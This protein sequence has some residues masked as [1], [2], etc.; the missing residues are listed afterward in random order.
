MHAQSCLTLCNPMDCR[1]PGSSSFAHGILQARIL[2]W[3]A[4]SSSRGPSQP[5]DQTCVSCIGGGFFTTDLLLWDYI[6]S[7]CENTE[8]VPDSSVSPINFLGCPNL[9]MVYRF[10]QV[11]LWHTFVPVK[12]VKALVLRVEHNHT[13]LKVFQQ[14]IS[15]P[16]LFYLLWVFSQE[17]LAAREVYAFH[18]REISPNI[19]TYNFLRNQDGGIGSRTQ[20]FPTNCEDRQAY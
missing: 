8:Y 6:Y 3:V 11:Y 18:E 2:E 12:A 5:K 15:C 17:Q 20:V 4:T 7:I 1:P 10:L 9:S 13:I 14:W 16:R 19:F